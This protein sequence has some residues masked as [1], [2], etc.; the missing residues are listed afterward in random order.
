MGRVKFTV[1]GRSL[2]ALPAVNESDLVAASEDVNLIDDASADDIEIARIVALAKEPFPDGED[3]PLT[4]FDRPE[5]E[6]V[7]EVTRAALAAIQAAHTRT[8]QGIQQFA[9]GRRQQDGSMA[10]LASA[11]EALEAATR[12]EQPTPG[13][14]V[15]ITTTPAA[16]DPC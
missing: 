10:V 15:T 13:V 12:R 9:S 8:V 16:H 3:E 4:A 5:R 2:P 1:R 11:V 14:F 6:S 7:D